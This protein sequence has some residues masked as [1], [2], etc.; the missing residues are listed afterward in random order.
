M[1]GSGKFNQPSGIAPPA[2]GTASTI[3]CLNGNNVV[4]KWTDSSGTRV[5]T[6]EACRVRSWFVDIANNSKQNDRCAGD[7]QQAADATKPACVAGYVRKLLRGNRAVT[8]QIVMTLD[9]QLREWLDMACNEILTDVTFTV[10]GPQISAGPP[11]VYNA[12]EV[13]I[14]VASIRTVTSGDDNDDAIMT[15]DIVGLYDPST[16]GAATG[17]VTNTIA[18]GF[19]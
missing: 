6:S 17:S 7:P 19:K 13:S 18:T 16:G 5:L 14:P 12:L 4:I 8:A 2:P 3:Q 15:L 9:D 10:N 11:I 1:L